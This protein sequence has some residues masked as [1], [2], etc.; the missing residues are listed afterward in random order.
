M[1]DAAL[2]PVPAL[3]EI[4]HARR[5][6]SLGDEVV[7]ALRDVSLVI[8]SGEH[9]A[10][11]GPSGSGKSTLMNVIGCLDQV[12]EGRYLLMGSTSSTAAP[13]NWPRSATGRSASSSSSST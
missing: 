13:T 11:M 7:H 3:I 12:D 6:Y 5:S 4:E 10:I 2:E 8:E 1:S 9:V